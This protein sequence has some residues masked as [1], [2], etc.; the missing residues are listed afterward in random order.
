MYGLKTCDKKNIHHSLTDF[1]NSKLNDE[2]ILV[3]Q[4]FFVYHNQ[5]DAIVCI[6]TIYIIGNRKVSTSPQDSN[7]IISRNAIYSLLIGSVSIFE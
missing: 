1:Y 2:K 6:D 4:P 7:N 5:I 3:L